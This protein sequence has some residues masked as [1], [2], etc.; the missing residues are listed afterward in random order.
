MSLPFL[1]VNVTL[2]FF[3]IGVYAMLMFL[4]VEDKGI[5]DGR[6]EVCVVQ[7]AREELW[8]E[9]PFLTTTST[10]TTTTTQFGRELSDAGCT[11]IQG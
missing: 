4:W 7:R 5:R 11:Q 6:E 2:M 10:T 3:W 1:W 9:N 8:Q